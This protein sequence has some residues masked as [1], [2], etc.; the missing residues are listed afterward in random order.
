[1]L[2]EV[3]D[4][5]LICSKFYPDM[6]WHMIAILRGSWVPYKLP[7]RCS[8]L[9]ACADYDS[10]CMASC[11]GI[12][13]F[14]N[15]PHRTGHNP[16]MPITQ[17]TAWVAYRALTTPWG[18]Q[19]YATTCW[20]RI[21]NILIKNPLLPWAFVG[22]FTNKKDTGFLAWRISSVKYCRKYK[23]FNWMCKSVRKNF[24][25]IHHQCRKAITYSFPYT[26]QNICELFKYKQLMTKTRIR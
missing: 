12:V 21:W 18:W 26:G 14:H 1:M 13:T 15:W 6:L 8:V 9:W 25:N 2:K 3:V 7:K 17:N 16:H 22:H 11:C 24:S 23:L 20:G 4:F 19:P 10:S 5:L